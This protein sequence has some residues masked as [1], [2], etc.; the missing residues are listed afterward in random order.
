MTTVKLL[1]LISPWWWIC[2]R[3]LSS[4]WPP[5]LSSTATGNTQSH[6]SVWQAVCTSWQMWLESTKVPQ[7]ESIEL[8]G[9]IRVH[10]ST[11]K[12]RLW[13]A[14]ME[15]YIRTTSF[16]NRIV[17]ATV[18]WWTGVT[19]DTLTWNLPNYCK[20]SKIW[21]QTKV[22]LL[23]A[24][25]PT[26]NPIMRTTPPLAR[27]RTHT[28]TH[29]HTRTH[30]HAHTHTHPIQYIVSL[31]CSMTSYHIQ[32]IGYLTL[33]IRAFRL[34]SF[35]RTYTPTHTPNTTMTSYSVNRVLFHRFNCSLIKVMH[36]V[37]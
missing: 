25:Y 35:W 23:I 20:K 27:V 30:T 26:A 15:K 33:R 10:W 11:H 7:H 16:S 12:M 9:V 31:R 22:M 24:R 2:E 3:I 5:F 17:V 1:A 36:I 18:T 34:K 13:K 19:S 8:V 28:H 37:C 21:L 14:W 4:C 29:T 32:C 6:G